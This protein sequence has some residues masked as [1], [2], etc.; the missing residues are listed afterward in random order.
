M[1][2]DDGL[3][4]VANT[5]RFTLRARFI[6]HTLSVLRIPVVGIVRRLILPVSAFLLRG[7]PGG[8][9]PM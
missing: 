9:T 6:R 1:S 2:D 8:L 5:G 3:P 7:C 4:R